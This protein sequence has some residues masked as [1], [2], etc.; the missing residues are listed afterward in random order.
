MSILD[1]VAFPT[2]YPLIERHYFDTPGAIA[3][4]APPKTGYVRAG[5][6]ASGGFKDNADGWGGG[7]SF[8]FSAEACAA[9]ATFTGWVG[10]SQFCRSSQN[11][12][13]GD[14]WIRRANSSLLVYAD[15]GR[16]DGSPGLLANCTGTIKRSGSAAASDAGGASAGDDADQYPLGF[17][18]QGASQTFAPWYGGGGG[19]QTYGSLV[20]LHPPGDG[21]LCVEFYSRNA[22]YD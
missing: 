6:Q 15:R 4:T 3:I 20:W 8:A 22:G 17:G 5:A 14:S 9:G 12:T 7:A 13:S 2:G 1:S 11:T 10:D 19:R 18:G 16:P 21:R